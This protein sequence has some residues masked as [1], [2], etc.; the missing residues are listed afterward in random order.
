MIPELISSLNECPEVSQIILTQNI[1]E[2]IS[3]DEK[4]NLTIIKN[5]S[6]K[7]YGENHN[8]AFNISKNDYFCVLNPDIKI[9]KNPFLNLTNFLK[10]K[11]VGLVSPMIV[12][13]Q[14][15]EEDNMRY[16]PTLYLHFKKLIGLSQGIF[17][18]NSNE[19]YPDW[20]GGM[21]MLFKKSAFEIVNGFDEKFF[22]YYE[23][24]DICARLMKLNIKVA[25][26][27]TVI[28]AHD[29][30]RDSRVKYNYMMLHAKSLARY[31]LKYL[32]R[33][34]KNNNH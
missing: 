14:N 2:D 3:I 22:L 5:T 6:P 28:V 10:E 29:A 7:G 27:K 1:P 31:Y 33:L 9:L 15:I 16:F 19:V 32:F 4:K 23:D 8:N 11:D 26:L 34:P 13:L 17:K 25:G 20:V 30:R 24:V 12:N 18:S 21:F